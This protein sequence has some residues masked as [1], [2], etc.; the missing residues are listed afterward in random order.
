[1]RIIQPRATCLILKGF[2]NLFTIDGVINMVGYSTYRGDERSQIV[3][4]MGRLAPDV[5]GNC[6]KYTLLGTSSQWSSRSGAPSAECWRRPQVSSAETEPNS[7]CRVPTSGMW[8]TGKIKQ[9]D[10]YPSFSIMHE[11]MGIPPD[12][13]SAVKAQGPRR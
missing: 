7:T 11:Q 5:S 10:C 13:A 2:N 1:M 9:F 3:A 8:K 4:F 12:F 6:I